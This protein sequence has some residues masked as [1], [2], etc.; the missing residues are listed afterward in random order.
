MAKGKHHK[1]IKYT[2]VTGGTQLVYRGGWANGTVAVATL[3]VGSRIFV[4]ADV[5]SGFG[6]LVFGTLKSKPGDRAQVRCI[7]QLQV[8]LQ[9]G[10]A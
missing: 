4:L 10:V 9:K 8:E 7:S 3:Y 2:S 6:Q 5:N 1:A